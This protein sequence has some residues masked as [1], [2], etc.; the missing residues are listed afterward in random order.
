VSQAEVERKFVLG[1]DQLLPDVP[2][3]GPAVHHD[4]LATYYDTRHFALA[5]AHLVVRR[6][7]GGTDAGWHVKLPGADAEHRREFHAPLGE[8]RLP[9]QLRLLVAETVDGEALLPVATLATGRD[10][11]PLVGASGETLALLCVDEVTVSAAGGRQRWREA[12]V[13]LVEGDDDLLTDL[14]RR[15]AAA[16]IVP[17]P[18]ASK[19]G[20]ALRPAIAADAARPRGDAAGAWDAVADYLSRQVGTLQALEAAVLRD[21]PDAVHRTRVATRRLRSA[22]RTFAPVIAPKPRIA[23]LRDELRWHATA[24][25]GPRDAEVLREHLLETLAADGRAAPALLGIVGDELAARHA[26]AHAALVTTMTLPRY[27]DLHRALERLLADGGRGESTAGEALPK[28]L[29]K[30]VRRVRRD[31]E[32]AEDPQTIPEP[33]EGSV[34]AAED[35]IGEASTRSAI[36][37]SAGPGGLERWHRVRKSA[38]AVRYSCE[39]LVPVFGEPA[40]VRALAWEAV[41]EALGELQDSV[42]AQ[43]QLTVLADVA[44]RAGVDA[45]VLVDLGGRQRARGERALSAGREALAAALELGP[46][47][48]G[49]GQ[50]AM[51]A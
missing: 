30:A 32:A 41:T 43:E 35:G 10:Q 5:R 28:L 18:S 17:S 27:D 21:D 11:A 42:V 23:A 49:P 6:R 46:V 15:F 37:G 13:E 31:L 45:G 12:E 14:T 16:G 2:G 9:E 1:P 24:L 26:A 50:R 20:Q 7:E 25:G 19:A 48:P 44:T 34:R 22:L 47:V 8:P 36:V 39:A 3:L 38:K 40:Q 29:R 33:V 4:L 51:S